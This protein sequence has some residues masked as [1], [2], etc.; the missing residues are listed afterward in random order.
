M[1]RVVHG[2]D[3]I[4]TIPL[5]T[6]KAEASRAM[7]VGCRSILEGTALVQNIADALGDRL[8]AIAPPVMARTPACEVAAIVEL[9]R[10]GKADAIVAIGGSS[11][12]DAAKFAALELGGGEPSVVAQGAKPN[13]RPLTLISVPTSLSASEF[14]GAAGMVE[15][16]TK[17]LAM[18]DRFLPWAVILD[19]KATIDT[20]PQLWAS[21]GAKAVDHAAET[22]WRRL[23]H[24]LGDAMASRRCEGFPSICR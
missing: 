12:S 24:P 2:I 23:A 8:S 11:V 6:D 20:A 13:A 15:D 18:D 5:L 17:V 7:V 14:H 21:S 10:S 1:G 4:G 19:P 22:I 9:A 16:G 3:A